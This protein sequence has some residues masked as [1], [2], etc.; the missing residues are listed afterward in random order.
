[1][2]SLAR[3]LAHSRLKLRFFVVGARGLASG[4]SAYRIAVNVLLSDD[5][6]RMASKKLRDV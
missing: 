1:M 5:G 2:I 4:T 6:S 3:K